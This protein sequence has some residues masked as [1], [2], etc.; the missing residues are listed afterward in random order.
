MKLY[1]QRVDDTQ[2][3]TIPISARQAADTFTSSIAF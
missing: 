2:K 1:F 3:A